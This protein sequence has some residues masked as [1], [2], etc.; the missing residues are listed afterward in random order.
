MPATKFKCSI[1]D[2]G[3]GKSHGSIQCKQCNSWLHLQCAEI[4]EKDLTFLKEK[5]KSFIFIC[6]G[7]SEGHHECSVFDQIKDLKCSFENIAK[8]LRADNNDFKNTMM[9]MIADFKNETSLCIKEMK[10]DIVDC[11]KLVDEVDASTKSNI[12]KLEI[13]NNALHRRLNRSEVVVRGL[14][15]GLN[16]LSS[17]VVSLCK[18]YNID[19]IEQQLNHVCYIN[20]M[21][22]I[23]IKFNNVDVRDLLMKE[24]FKTRSLRVCDVLGGEIQARV[25]LNDHFPPIAA[26]LNA[27]CY[28]LSRQKLISKFKVLNKDNPRAIIT[29]NDGKR[30]ECDLAGCG[31]L[32]ASNMNSAL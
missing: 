1:C 14:P 3:I 17:A 15:S 16:N 18:H 29:T 5:S 28:K 8:E 7:C 13:E 2:E 6:P 10:S 12:S 26:R 25:Y 4:S 19:I 30:M 11:R 27:L 31:N 23:I 24:Y 20:N 21:R 32:M 9:K 22:Q